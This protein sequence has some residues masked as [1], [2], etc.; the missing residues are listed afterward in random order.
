MSHRM[1]YGVPK[2]DNADGRMLET[3]LTRG[4]SA[5][6]RLTAYGAEGGVLVTAAGRGTTRGPLAQQQGARGKA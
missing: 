5:P 3:G 6:C 2:M 4:K 1:M